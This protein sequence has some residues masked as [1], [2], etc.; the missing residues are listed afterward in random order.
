[1]TER[2]KH[3]KWEH[4]R[5]LRSQIQLAEYNPREITEEAYNG[6]HDGLVEH[7][8]VM[9]LVWNETSGRLI[10]G[11]QRL[12]VMDEEH[13]ENDYELTVLAVKFNEKKEKQAN[14]ALNNPSAQGRFDILLLGQIVK[15]TGLEGT[16]FTTS[17]IEMHIAPADA[18][19]IFGRQRTVP[20]A[21]PVAPAPATGT[22]H[23]TIV[24]QS[25]ASAD[26]FAERWGLDVN[27]RYAAGE[28]L[29]GIIKQY[30][31]D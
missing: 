5:I 18:D 17:T 6:L 12:A 27:N 9:S 7:G 2:S 3:Q 30:L 21:A 16:G 29:L 13:G 31:L 8:L 10:G 4:K 19:E 22:K 24:F 25:R 26:A 14:L 1:M 23:V 20:K 28:K 11:H 15:E